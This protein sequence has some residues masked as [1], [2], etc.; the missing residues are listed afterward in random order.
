[1]ARPEVAMRS[2]FGANTDALSLGRLRRAIL[3][4]RIIKDATRARSARA[5]TEIPRAVSSNCL[6]CRGR[7]KY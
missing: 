2:L 1:M 6:V 3:L 4:R 7:T 5:G